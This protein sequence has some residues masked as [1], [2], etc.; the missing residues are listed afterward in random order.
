M[1]RIRARRT[2]CAAAP[3]PRRSFPSRASQQS[4][5][6][7]QTPPVLPW[8]SVLYMYCLLNV[9][10]IW[11]TCKTCKIGQT[12]QQT[13]LF[14]DTSEATSVQHEPAGATGRGFIEIVSISCADHRSAGNERKRTCKN[15]VRYSHE[16]ALQNLENVGLRKL[17]MLRG[18][19]A[20]VPRRMS[21]LTCYIL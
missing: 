3:R 4:W 21:S 6:G 18:R 19:S 15:R 10:Y 20:S 7:S 2:S 5:N 16:R 12:S 14:N 8:F 1:F 17:C 13:V 9:N 11:S